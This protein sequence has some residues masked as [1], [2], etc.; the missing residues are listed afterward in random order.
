MKKSELE[1]LKV[2]EDSPSP[3]AEKPQAKAKASPLGKFDIESRRR[4]HELKLN[5]GGK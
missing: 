1:E 3:L 2:M 4:A 5:Q